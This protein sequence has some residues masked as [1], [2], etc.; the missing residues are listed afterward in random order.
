MPGET[1]RYLSVALFLS[2]A[3][4]AQAQA[5][6]QSTQIVRSAFIPDC[7]P[8][9]GALFC[10]APLAFLYAEAERRLG[11]SD[12]VY[13]IDGQTLNI[14]A[15]SPTAEARLT[16]TI[17]EGLA[18]MSTVGSL[19][20]ASYQ[21][22]QLD[23][24]I[25]EIGLA[26][27]PDGTTL[28]YRGPLAPPAP[29]SNAT[30]KGKL[31]VV[32]VDSAALGGPRKVTVYTPP[33][34]PP[35][36]G[37]PAVITA[38]GQAIAPYVAMIDAMI[39]R[40]EIR[41][42]AVAALWSGTNGGEYLR[43]HDPDAYSRHAMFVQREALP[44]LERRFHVTHDAGRRLLF[45]TDN[46]GDWAVQAALRDP[47]TASNVA[48]FSVSGLSEPPFRSGRRLHLQMT[49]GAYEG[50]FLRGSRQICSL[51]SASGTPCKLEVTYSGHAP[52][53][54]QA[55]LAKALKAVFPPR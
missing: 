4:T 7:G 2:L 32:E 39:E 52:L 35:T 8:K 9:P 37:W 25:F 43:G 10:R 55:E 15:R 21:A 50:P 47:T 27:R 40:R 24:S 5:P 34:A 13:W 19:W 38:D 42:V 31:E 17:Q 49:A 28:V 48:A 12:L 18:P 53:I 46:G 29:P 22:P 14:A 54:W 3:S 16:G 30:L 33:G 6:K 11:G 45:G 26:G 44:M 20:G 36:G 1:S 41:P 51:A 23:R